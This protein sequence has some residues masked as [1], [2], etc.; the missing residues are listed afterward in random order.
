MEITLHFPSFG[1]TTTQA[2]SFPVLGFNFAKNWHGNLHRIA[3][4]A[5]VC[6]QRKSFMFKEEAMSAE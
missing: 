2:F 1:H 4:L 6:L 5:L 3:K